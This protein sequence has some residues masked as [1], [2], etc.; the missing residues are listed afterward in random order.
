MRTDGYGQIGVG[1]KVLASH[2]VA[3]Q[4]ENGPI[5]PG[6]VVCHKCDNQ[7]CVNPEHLYLDTQVENIRDM[8]TKKRNFRPFGNINGMRKHPDR[9]PRGEKHGQSKITQ[10]EASEIREIRTSKGWTI[11][12]L[13]KFF[14]ISPSTVRDILNGKTWRGVPNGK[15]V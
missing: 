7:L 10:K 2:R 12:R 15:E 14:D 4:L 5:P 13:A 8:V 1:N 6:M 3:Y 9:V 11:R